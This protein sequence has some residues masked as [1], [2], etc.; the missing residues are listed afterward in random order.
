MNRVL[1]WRIDVANTTITKEYLERAGWVRGPGDAAGT[2][3]W[4]WRGVADVWIDQ[5]GDTFW[6]DSTYGQAVTTPR[7]LEQLSVLLSDISQSH[8]EPVTPDRPAQVSPAVAALNEAF[9]RDPQAMHALLTNRIPCNRD[10]ADDP[11]VVVEVNRVLDDAQ[12]VGALGL[13]NG[14]LSATGQPLVAAKYS[15]TG[16]GPIRLLGFCD[17]VPVPA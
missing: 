3:R 7:Q 15:D 12:T 9:A 2:F 4:T 6:V 11:F 13:V 14:V 17:Y 8:R 1:E 10:L 16:A 5:D